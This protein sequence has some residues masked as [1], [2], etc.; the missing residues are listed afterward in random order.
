VPNSATT[1]Y[2]DDELREAL[3]HVNSYRTLHEIYG[4]F[5]G[6][7]AAAKRV[8]SS[9]YLPLVYDVD[10]EDNISAEDSEKVH[11]NLI[12]LWNFIARWKPQDEPFSFP[13]QTYADTA[14]GLLEHAA[15]DISLI[16]FFKK[17]FEMAAGQGSPGIATA[18]RD[19]ESVTMELQHYAE[20]YE[21]VE[22]EAEVKNLKASEQKFEELEVTIG[23]CIAR[24]TAMRKK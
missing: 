17:G 10:S 19:L 1:Y 8:D 9:R 21:A 6:C 15:D 18:M 3:S 5:Y 2:D 22:P 24:V 23:R 16:Q 12:S 4:L 7:M 11:R 14:Q 13:D 20:M